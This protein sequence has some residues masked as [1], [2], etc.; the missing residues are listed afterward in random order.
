MAAG[1]FDEWQ[2]FYR[3]EPFGPSREDLRAGVIACMLASGPAKPETFFP[4][5]KVAVDPEERDAA[6]LAGLMAL[7]E[8]STGSPKGQREET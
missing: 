8:A 3:I 1:E 4:N 6:I 2:E 7:T 5:L